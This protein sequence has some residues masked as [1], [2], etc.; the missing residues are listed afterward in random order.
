LT[1]LL[2][3]PSNYLDPNFLTQFLI[4]TFVAVVLGGFENIF[5]VVIGAVVFGLIQSLVATYVTTELG[6]TTSFV[7][8]VLVLFFLPQGL[9]GRSLPRVPEA[10]IPRTIH[11]KF[12][13]VAQFGRGSRPTAKVGPARRA[14]IRDSQ[15]ALVLPVIIAGVF[16]LIGPQLS[17]PDLL[18]LATIAAYLIATLGVD[19]LFGYS[20][21]L[22]LGSSGFLLG[23]AY[24]CVIVQRDLHV[25]FILGLVIAAV[26]CG[27]VGGILGW[28]VS[29]LG[30]VY[31]VVTTLAFALAVPELASFFGTFTGGPNGVVMAIPQSLASGPG[32]NLDLYRFVTIVALIVTVSVMWLGRSTIGRVWKSVREN[33][34]AAAAAGVNVRLQKVAAFAISSALCGLGGALIVSLSGYLTPN[35]FSLWDS[36]YLVVAVVV[37]GRNSVLGAAIGA[38]FVVGVPYAS[39]GVPALS[40]IVLG[41]ALIVILILRPNGLRSLI[42]APLLWALDTVLGR[43]SSPPHK[44]D[45]GVTLSGED[46][47]GPDGQPQDDHSISPM[48]GGG[49]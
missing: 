28:P 37:G 18:L 2:V 44:E 11:A 34:S 15:W 26:L 7:V 13:R 45:S 14:S 39:S 29:R 5:G 3:T 12:N 46:S 31:L 21:Q 36:I 22:S 6:S 35:S 49:T 38:A 41:L 4:V 30:G 9:L 23:G 47:R 32:R 17:S 20:G 1:A 19:L 27:V 24:A 42:V 33:E 43:S 25:P 8:I 16:L 48:P 40:G 10:T